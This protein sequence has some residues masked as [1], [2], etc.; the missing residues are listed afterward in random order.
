MIESEKNGTEV[1]L[2]RWNYTYEEHEICFLYI[3]K[4]LKRG[5]AVA[6]GQRLSP[7]PAISLAFVAE[8]KLIHGHMI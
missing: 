7:T 1:Y 5:S 3:D 4:I 6:L 2:C 8:I